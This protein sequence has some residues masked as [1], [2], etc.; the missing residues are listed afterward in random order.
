[1]DQLLPSN[2]LFG[3]APLVTGEWGMT[4]TATLSLPVLSGVPEGSFFIVLNPVDTSMAKRN[5]RLDN[6]KANGT[7]QPPP[8]I[9][10]LTIQQTQSPDTALHFPSTQNAGD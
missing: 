9:N 7:P 4:K 3:K 6:T 2:G 8:P 1:M 5:T 10:F